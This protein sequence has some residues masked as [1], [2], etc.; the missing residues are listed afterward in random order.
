[1]LKLEYK[2]KNDLE[3]ELYD[4][5]ILFAYHSNKIENQEIDYHDTREIFDNGKVQSFSGDPRT[6]FEIQNQKECYYYLLDKLEKREK[7]SIELIKEIHKILT[8]GTY[9]EARYLKGERPGEFKKGDYIVG[10]SE[11]GSNA[12]DVEK[13][14]KDLL[15]EIYDNDSDDYL[16]I[17]SYFHL[18]FE[19]I[20]PFADGNGRVGRTLL[21]YYFITNSIKPLIIYDEDKKDYYKCLQAYDADE[22][23][24][25]MIKFLSYS[26]DKTWKKKNSQN[27]KKL[28]SF[29]M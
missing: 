21:N 23:I 7:I 11:T 17:G 24:D 5:W 9:D 22:N 14:L 8:Q 3:K 20:H 6:L 12:E 16:T 19:A 27:T 4:F 25:L 13:E 29:L 26:Q 15:S 28:I 1:M 2:T 10:K 18:R